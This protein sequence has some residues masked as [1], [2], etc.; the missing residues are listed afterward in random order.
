MPGT[1]CAVAM[2]NNNR[3]ATKKANLQI[4][5]HSFPKEKSI[6]NIWIQ[7]CRRDG[8]WNA[9]TSYV[10]SAHFQSTDYQRDLKAELLNLPPKQILNLNA[11]PSLFLNTRNIAIPT[12]TLLTNRDQQ[13]TNRSIV[14]EVVNTAEHG[15]NIEQYKS[16]D[17]N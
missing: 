11:V 12:E 10:C 15:D 4:K 7:R 1:R 13:R 2:C 14:D 6:R 3:K 5:Y 17:T 16:I 8:K 9:S